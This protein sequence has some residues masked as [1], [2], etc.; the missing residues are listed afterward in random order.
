MTRHHIFLALALL[1]V[2]SVGQAQ[3]N[4][5]NE[6]DPDGTWRFYMVQD[7]KT[8]TADDFSA[9]MAQ[10][11][12]DIQNGRVS[13]VGYAQSGFNHTQPLSAPSNTSLGGQHTGSEQ[14]ILT[15][16]NLVASTQGAGWQP[17]TQPIATAPRVQ[18]SF[19]SNGHLTGYDSGSD[20]GN[21]TQAASYSSGYSSGY[22]SS[23]GGT[24]MSYD[25]GRDY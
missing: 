25:S 17:A 18:P 3:N 24:V 12:L 19:D 13:Q 21:S 9:W 22:S 23:Q 8:M 15:S 2:S 16:P 7:G 6:R 5:Q 4:G 14:A 10:R 1:G 11:G 20:L